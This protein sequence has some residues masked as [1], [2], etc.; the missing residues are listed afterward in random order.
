MTGKNSKMT[1]P[2]GLIVAIDG[3]AG[4]GKSTISSQLARAL[5]YLYIDTGAM[6]RAVAYLVRKQQLD[7]Q[8][9]AALERLCQDIE[10]TLV[11]KDDSLLVFAAGEDVSQQIR[12]PEISQLTS[13]V[14]MSAAVRAAMLRLQRKMGEAGGVVLEGR[15]VGTV[16]FPDAQVKFFLS[17]TAEERGR[18]RCE[19][20]RQK[21]HAADINETIAAVKARDRAD[22]NRTQAPLR[23][24]ADAIVIDST[25]L[26]ID[27]VLARMLT[28]V[29]QCEKEIRSLKEE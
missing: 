17:A 25:Q 7:P 13:Q 16:V 24:A 9:E 26:T 1:C 15:D 14:A 3:P 20:L 29:K 27:E 10:I 4:A 22:S 6:F 19:E 18:R 11:P 5:D 2:R 21:G 12:L 28:R 23:Q 8:D